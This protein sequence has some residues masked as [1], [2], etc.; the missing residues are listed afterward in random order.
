MSANDY[1]YCWACKKMVPGSDLTE[2]G[3]HDED[4][5][6]CGC[7]VDMSKTLSSLID[8]TPQL[9]AFKAGYEF[10]AMNE[11]FNRNSSIEEAYKTWK[12]IEV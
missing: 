3:R 2:G 11:A 6:G 5:G 1:V 4:K 10:G 7:C 8:E 12:G 9:A